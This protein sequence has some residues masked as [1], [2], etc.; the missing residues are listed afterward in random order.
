MT[1]SFF[2]FRSDQSNERSLS[3][4]SGRGR[5]RPS[6]VHLQSPSNFSFPASEHGRLICSV[7]VCASAV[8]RNISP[9]HS[10]NLGKTLSTDSVFIHSNS[11]PI[12]CTVTAVVR[13]PDLLA[14]GSSNGRGGGGGGAELGAATEES[15]SQSQPPTLP[16]KPLAS[17][18]KTVC[19]RDDAVP[20]YF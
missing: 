8:R 12:H 14:E 4:K 6:I 18:L 11:H 20:A 9:L 16:Q 2:F 5:P 17:A 19:G 15:Q 7:A 3:A 1:S 10:R 13:L